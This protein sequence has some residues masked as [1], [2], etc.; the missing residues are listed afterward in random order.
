MGAATT[1]RRS[2]GAGTQLARQFVH[3][4]RTDVIKYSAGWQPIKT[5]SG[6]PFRNADVSVNFSAAAAGQS[7]EFSFG[8]TSGGR[9]DEFV[10]L[11]GVFDPNTLAR[12]YLNN[13]L[14]AEYYL[15]SALAALDACVLYLDRGTFYQSNDFFS[16]PF[17]VLLPRP[18]VNMLRFVNLP[19]PAS[20]NKSLF[21]DGIG[22]NL[23]G[24]SLP[25]TP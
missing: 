6:D 2:V 20:D 17:L 4:S 25:A 14:I 16:S 22:L 11:H 21:F 8:F 23:R 5:G 9:S 15:N 12:I 10:S 18:G 24:G 1:Y 13:T 3:D 19:S 7:L